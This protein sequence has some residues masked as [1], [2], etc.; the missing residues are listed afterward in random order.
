MPETKPQSTSTAC[1]AEPVWARL[2]KLVYIGGM[3]NER[4]L[5]LLIIAP[6]NDFCD[7]P[8]AYRPLLATR[9]LL[10]NVA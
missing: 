7:L 6:Q 1:V 3:A 8:E 4:N 10:V 5:P 9:E 2:G